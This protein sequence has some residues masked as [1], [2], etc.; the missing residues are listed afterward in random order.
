[1]SVFWRIHTQTHTHDTG[2]MNEWEGEKEIIKNFLS[3][4][5]LFTIRWRF[6]NDW[7]DAK[8]IR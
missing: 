2:Y 3:L 8:I 6:D 7:Y 1:M 4:I 5:D